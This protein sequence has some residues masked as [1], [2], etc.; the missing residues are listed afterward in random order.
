[1]KRILF[2][3]LDGVGLGA[4]DP[5][6]NP[7]AAVDLP[8]F[9]ELLG[10]ARLLAGDAPVENQRVT[11]LSIDTRLGVAGM[12]QSATGQAA[13]LTGKNVPALIGEHYGPK[14]NPAI[15]K[16]LN[17]GNLFSVLTKRGKKTALL[18]AFPPGYFEA[19]ESGRRLPGAIAMSARYAGL[20]LK[21]AADLYAGH[22]LS[23]DFTGQGW[24]TML[25]FPD[26]PVLTPEQ[27]GERLARLSK[28]Y[29]MAFFE[30]WP[31]DVVGHR[32]N[33]QG[34]I[35]ILQT[36]DGVL[37]GLLA[38][39]QDDQG[40]ILITSD[41]GNMEDLHTRRHTRN[42]VPCLLI[43]NRELRSQFA[44]NLKDLTGVYP[45]ILG[46]LEA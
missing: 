2:L 20:K 18:N 30:H 13:L 26:L 40:L 22:A 9:G 15:G 16:I 28:E 43:G 36:L 5:Q 23:A 38:H 29:D 35:E 19:I 44:H 17:N 42:T 33:M 45:A 11:L 21:T 10:D 41:H 14:P 27:A 46:L 8:V 1:M 4:D 24:R 25:G 39:W 32:Q 31:T 3:F 7:F 34:A 37:A 6:A 12:P